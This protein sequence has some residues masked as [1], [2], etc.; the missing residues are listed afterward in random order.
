MVWLRGNRLVAAGV[1]Q[2]RSVRTFSG[3]CEVAIELFDPQVPQ[4]FVSVQPLPSCVQK[5]VPWLPRPR[6]S[7]SP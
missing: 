2:S 1:L 7:M 6:F 3:Q 4:V 5:V